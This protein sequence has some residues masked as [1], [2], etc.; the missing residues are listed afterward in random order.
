MGVS[1]DPEEGTGSLG[2][3]ITGI[4]E[5]LHRVKNRIH[6]LMIEQQVILMV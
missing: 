6:V 3:D 1:M 2:T 4:S 5:P